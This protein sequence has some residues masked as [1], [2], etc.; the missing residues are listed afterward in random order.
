MFNN[1]WIYITQIASL[2]SLTSV[3]APCEQSG[4]GQLFVER[5]ENSHAPSLVLVQQSTV[6]S[7]DIG[8]C[9]TG[10][11]SL[12]C[13]AQ[14]LT[15][16]HQHSWALDRDSLSI[17]MNYSSPTHQTPTSVSHIHIILMYWYV[18]S[19]ILFLTTQTFSQMYQGFFDVHKIRYS[20]L[21]SQV[22]K[23]YL[24]PF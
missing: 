2:A 3:C 24:H 4:A 23:P 9:F 6:L 14:L 11:T 21:A 10:F 7:S 16:T 13:L 18:W 17:R 8:I 5:S 15:L 19:C 22:K 12:L 20:Y 1:A